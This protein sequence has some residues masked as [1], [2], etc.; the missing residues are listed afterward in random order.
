[1]SRICAL[2]N[3]YYYSFNLW[4]NKGIFILTSKEIDALYHA[5]SHV[6]K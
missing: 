1:M 4:K 3:V 6:Y 2:A 5:I